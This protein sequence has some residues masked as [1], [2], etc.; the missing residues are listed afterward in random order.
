[1]RKTIALALFC[2][3]VIAMAQP[4]PDIP[5]DN[6]VVVITADIDN[7]WNAFDLLKNCNNAQDSINCIKSNYL[8]KGTEG[9][10]VFINKYNYTAEDYVKA[11]SQYPKFFNS[12][13]NNTLEVKN[14]ENSINLFYLK[15]KEYYPDYSLLKICFVISP[16]QS[17]GTTTGGYLF[18]GTEIIASSKEADLSEFGESVWAKVLAF[19]TNIRERLLFVVAH[20]TIH[21]LQINADF[22]NYELLNKSLN[23]GSADYIAELL[24]GA[25]ANHYLYDYG[26]R[27]EQELWNKF[28]KSLENNE[29]SD[30]WMYNY[31]RAE[32]GVPFDLGYYIG[33]K[34]AEKYYNNSADKKQALYD[35]IELKD[36]KAFL[37]K[38]GYGK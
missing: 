6:K 9:L 15:L 13:R 33:Y 19:D 17:G 29:S 30:N 5:K 23:E 18:I 11:I 25:R 24:T 8:G 27:H 4:N 10:T 12:I 35:I 36:P 32:E 22:N 7:F 16:L 34:I 31:D 20:E 14:I 1:M 37:E 28:K 2:Y 21:D 26:Q 3:S 38:S